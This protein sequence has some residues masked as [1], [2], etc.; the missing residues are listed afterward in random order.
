MFDEWWN[1]ALSDH[2]PAVIGREAREG[3]LRAYTAEGKDGKVWFGTP[4]RP[5]HALHALYSFYSLYASY[6]LHAPARPC[7]LLNASKRL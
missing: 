7:T 6:A 3:R 4:P 5:P 2:M 1:P